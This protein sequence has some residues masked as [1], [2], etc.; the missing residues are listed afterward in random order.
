MCWSSRQPD[1]GTTEGGAK[2]IK[3]T[4]RNVIRPVLQVTYLNS[5]RTHWKKATG[6]VR[7]QD[8]NEEGRKR[9]SGGAEGMCQGTLTEPGE[10]LEEKR[11]THKCSAA[12]N[13]ANRAERKSQE[14]AG[15]GKPIPDLVTF[16]PASHVPCGTDWKW[17]LIWSVLA[18]YHLT[19][20]EAFFLYLWHPSTLA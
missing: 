2:E 17:Y 8:S 9:K 5:R 18:G 16:A 3:G 13:G 15:R 1:Q 10:T 4:E 20:T 11:S 14:L 12:I 7:G 6:I 19:D